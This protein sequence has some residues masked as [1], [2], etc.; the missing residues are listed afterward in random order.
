MPR[1]SRRVWLPVLCWL[2]L[3]TPASAFARRTELRPGFNL[4]STQ[5]DV[6]LGKKAS[7]DANRQL[8]LIQ[9]ARVANYVNALGRRLAGYSAGPDYP[10]SFR[11]VNSAQI[12]A[13]ALPG[14]FVYVN[15][16]TIEAADNE[17]QLAGV[18]AHEISHVALRHGTNQLSR[19]AAAR[20]PLQIL[21]GVFSRGTLADQLAQIGIGIGF[22]SVFLKYSRS[23]ETQADIRGAQILYDADY[24]PRAMAQFFERLQA[25]HRQR[26][27]E[28][29]SD[30]PSPE[31]RVD[32]VNEEIDRLGGPRPGYQTDSPEFRRIKGLLKSL[33][34]PPKRPARPS[35]AAPARPQLPSG[36]LVVYEGENFRLQHPENWRVYAQTGAATIAPEGGILQGADGRTSVAYGA[37]L[38][39]FSSPAINRSTSLDDATNELIASL[40]KQNPD[41]RYVSRSRKTTRLAGSRACSLRFSAPSPMPGKQEA[42]WI[43]TT[44]RP[45]GLFFI[46]LISPEQDFESYRPAFERLLQSILFSD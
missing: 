36:R 20:L 22:T 31:R 41:M 5:H 32:R 3:L 1:D 25:E 19:A 15:R 7:A 46:A 39:Y 17:A 30:H 40:E 18:I 6:E 27:I 37:F 12:N 21:G 38:G 11:V 23:A 29:F 24:D 14:G 4:F 45:Q 26:S 2:L 44:M 42:D 33:P 28:F 13:F 35:D 9:D 10:Y 16:G 43:V 8:P 34:L